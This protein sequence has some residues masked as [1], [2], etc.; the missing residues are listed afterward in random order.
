MRRLTGAFQQSDFQSGEKAAIPT[1][2]DR[3]PAL[4]A[5]FAEQIDEIVG[6]LFFH[7]QNFFH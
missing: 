4:F 7:G 1:R 2:R 6:V 5:E 3:T